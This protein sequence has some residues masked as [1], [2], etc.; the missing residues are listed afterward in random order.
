MSSKFEIDI[1]N[2]HGYIIG[3]HGDSQLPLWS[4]TNIAG[5]SVE[6]F[7]V[8]RGQ[9][10]TQQERID[11]IEQIRLAGAQ[12]I[13]NKGATYF[14]I[15]AVVGSIVE[16]LLKDKNTI[17]TVSSVITGYYGITDVA[18]SL[19]CILDADGVQGVLQLK[20]TAEEE[21]KLL[22]CAATMKGFMKNIAL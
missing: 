2:V 9:I 5:Q 7:C 16:T 8:S 15:S 13:E 3:E 18:L 19:P 22:T 17:R 14:A 10:F 11:I 6:D 21:A 4:A 12:V 20:L 1:H